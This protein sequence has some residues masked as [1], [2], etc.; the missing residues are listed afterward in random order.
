MS[1]VRGQFLQG[2][3][4][5]LRQGE[6]ATNSKT[7]LTFK[8]KG[9]LLTRVDRHDFYKVTHVVATDDT[10]LDAYEMHAAF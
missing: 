4:I 9:D 7:I 10:R 1:P 8:L 2:S 6:A 5:V 3:C